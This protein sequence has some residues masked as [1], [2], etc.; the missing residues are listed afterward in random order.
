MSL[1]QLA[2]TRGLTLLRGGAGPA[3]GPPASRGNRAV[4]G[5][6]GVTQEAGEGLSVSQVHGAWTILPELSWEMGGPW[7]CR[8]GPFLLQ[9]T[10]VAPFPTPPSLEEP[11]LPL[12]FSD[13]PPQPL[14]WLGSP[15][16]AQTGDG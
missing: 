1:V 16:L 7:G 10:P 12:P 5:S 6:G 9:R 15:K 11:F 2:V 14:P 4:L 3:W 13:S 8:V